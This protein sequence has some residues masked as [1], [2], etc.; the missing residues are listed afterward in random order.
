MLYYTQNTILCRLGVL[1]VSLNCVPAIC[2]SFPIWQINSMYASNPDKWK[3][4][5][6]DCEVLV[7]PG[8]VNSAETFKS[9]DKSAY[10]PH[11]LKRQS[12]MEALGQS[13]GISGCCRQEPSAH[14]QLTYSQ[15]RCRKWHMLCWSAKIFEMY[16]ITSG[17]KISIDNAQ[18][19]KLTATSSL[20][21]IKKD[22]P[23]AISL[24]GLDKCID[25]VEDTSSYLSYLPASPHFPH[26]CLHTSQPHWTKLPSKMRFC[27]AAAMVTG[28][29][30]YLPWVHLL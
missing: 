7:L 8:Y 13:T 15:S 9:I 19:W 12:W 16:F 18:C 27:L 21:I 23:W 25:Y 4:K 14:L 29:C 2:I 6:I 20:S 17:T 3:N 30:H 5:G 24:P 26:F 28:H 1:S 10:A 11:F 22:N